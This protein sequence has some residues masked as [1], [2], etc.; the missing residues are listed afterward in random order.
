MTAFASECS[1]LTL[2]STVSE[3]KLKLNLAALGVL[4]LKALSA[5][6]PRGK[7]C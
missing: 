7:R 1:G 2:C 6:T 4:P 5:P 3:S